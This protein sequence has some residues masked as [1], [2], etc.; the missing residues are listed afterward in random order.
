MEC[1]LV[2]KFLKWRVI[3]ANAVNFARFFSAATLG[4]RVG[5]SNKSICMKQCENIQQR[6]SARI[7]FRQFHFIG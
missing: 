4:C 3:A 5:K 1:A 7:Q 2:E 6:V